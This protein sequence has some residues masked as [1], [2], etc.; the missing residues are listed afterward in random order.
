MYSINLNK[1]ITN[2]YDYFNIPRFMQV[3]FKSKTNKNTIKIK[4]K[5][6]AYMRVK[7]K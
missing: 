4:N 5:K 1:K 3:M 6:L 7:N 2:L